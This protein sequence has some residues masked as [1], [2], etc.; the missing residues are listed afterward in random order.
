MTN[1]LRRPLLAICV[2]LTGITG[3]AVLGVAVGTVI[4]N[5][6]LFGIGV[7]AVLV[8]YGLSLIAFAWFTAKGHA[9]ALGLIVGSSLLHLMVVYSLLTS[10]DRTQMVGTLIVAPFILATAV[11]AIWAVGRRELERVS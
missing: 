7:A 11:T 8:L 9:W 5:S 4:A 10:P 3:L 2:I 6:G 1:V